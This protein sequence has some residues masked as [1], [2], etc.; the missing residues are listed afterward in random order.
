MGTYPKAWRGSGGIRDS[1]GGQAS[2]FLVMDGRDTEGNVKAISSDISIILDFPPSCIEFSPSYP[3]SFVVGTYCLE[4][5][6]EANQTTSQSRTG[7]LILFNLSDGK[8]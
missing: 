5:E 8:L 4:T 6:S 7:T 3:D 1:D 2:S